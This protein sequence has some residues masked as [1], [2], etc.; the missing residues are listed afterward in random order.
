MAPLHYLFSDLILS[1]DS[2]LPE[3]RRAHEGVPE[4]RITWS[5]SPQEDRPTFA[6]WTTPS[7]GQWLT[8]ADVP[9]GFLLTFAEHTQFF[10]SRDASRVDVRPA[11]DTPPE[12][13]RH[14]LLNQVLPLVLSRRGRLVLHASAISRDGRVAAF[15]GRSG[16]GKST[17][18]AACAAA[19]AAV[20]TDDCLVLRQH[21]GTWVAVPCDAGVR[22]WPDAL[23]LLGWP[24]A[25]GTGMAHFTDKRRVGAGYASMAFERETL[26]LV[27]IFQ[28][29]RPDGVP[30]TGPVRGRAAVI[31]LASELFRL[32]VRDARESRWQFDAISALA[33]DLPIEALPRIQ[34]VEAASAILCRM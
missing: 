34:P 4:V 8:F 3:L 29:S 20:V 30:A 15:I 28:L 11:K 23:N 25:L 7:G 26:P 9:E 18:A 21:G 32:D 22:L 16:A 17:M 31:A 6:A 14:L 24:A 27:R 33:A 12:T 2:P 19:G 1:I 13:T 10:V 5:S